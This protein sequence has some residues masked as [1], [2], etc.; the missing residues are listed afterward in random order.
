VFSEP[1]DVCN[2]LASYFS[3]V[4]S[5]T[6]ESIAPHPNLSFRQLLDC[7]P[8]CAPFSLRTVSPSVVRS[9]LYSIKVSYKNAL[10][11][12]PSKVLKLSVDALLVP[13]THII[14]FSIASGVFPSV[15]KTS[16]VIPIFKKGD[17][18]SPS[19]YRP[20]SLIPFLSKVLEKVVK[21]QISNFFASSSF[22][23]EAQYGFMP[24][25]STDL[26]LCD[27]SDFVTNGCI[28]GNGVIGVFID[29]AKA[30][31]C[32]A[33]NLLIEIM[34]H[35]GFSGTTLMWFGSYLSNRS[36]MVNLNGL[37]S[38]P[39]SIHL[40]VPQGSILGPILFLIYIN[41][42]L[43]Y[44]NKLSAKC[45]VISYADDVTVL[46]KVDGNNVD[47]DVIGF[48]SILDKI[49]YIYSALRLRVNASKTEVVL[50]GNALSG[51]S[52]N[53]VSLKF[54]GVALPPSPSAKCLGLFFDSDLKWLTYFN[55]IKP[56]CYAVLASLR[57]LRSLHFSQSQLIKFYKI[58]LL[59]VLSY[60]IVI[61]GGT[62]KSHL[63][64]L[65]VTQNDALRV[66]FGRTR[67]QSL[68]DIY[69][70]E[71][72]GILR[73]R[74]LFECRVGLLMFKFVNGIL[75][76]PYYLDVR[77]SNNSSLRS[78][79]MRLLQLNIPRSQSQSASPSHTFVRIWNSIPLDIRDCQSYSTFRMMLK[80]FYY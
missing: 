2:F 77:Y 51:V 10:S 40:G 15:F 75:P 33:H 65:E 76:T 35:I 3:T 26:A 64:A 18:A 49:S 12:V 27:I 74:D 55:S 17:P 24:N 44:V 62:Y 48:Q 32:V 50:F 59:P 52:I 73:L 29:V 41:V 72:Y 39:K 37:S 31:D 34:S 63:R 13:L 47:G 67:R 69:S 5:S 43:I 80:S 6:V 61:W 30:F 9:C 22:I 7:L 11:S 8:D 68:D 46:F 19:N 4:G 54:D 42:L 14:N 23:S 71:S 16:I 79:N 45:R 53:N 20:I 66:I 1:V 56:K 21:F 78:A 36:I 70:N 58:L 60:S 38:S 25:R 57:R 28:N